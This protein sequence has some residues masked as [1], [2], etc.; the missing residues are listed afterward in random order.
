MKVIFPVKHFIFTQYVTSVAICRRL[1]VDLLCVTR[2]YVVLFYLP[3][4][5]PYSSIV[6]PS[7]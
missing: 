3:P 4:K 2:E 1:L 7:I 6:R 5:K